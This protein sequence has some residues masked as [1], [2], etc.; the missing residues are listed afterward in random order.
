VLS[1]V[2]LQLNVIQDMYV[3]NGKGFTA[4]L[5]LEKDYCSSVQI[6][7]YAWSEYTDS[8]LGRHLA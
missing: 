3:I 7:L 6:I 8:N 2:R 1:T 4:E 5:L